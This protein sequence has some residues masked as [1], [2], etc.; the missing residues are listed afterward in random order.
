MEAS[1]GHAGP[2]TTPLTPDPR[3]WPLPVSSEPPLC[4]VLYVVPL[5]HTLDTASAPQDSEF[6]D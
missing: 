3:C 1:E 4:D 6:E 5:I 2:P